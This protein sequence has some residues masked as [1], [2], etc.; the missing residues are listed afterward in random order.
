MEVEDTL[1]YLA[2]RWALR[3]SLVDHRTGVTGSFAGDGE[4][5]TLGPRGRYEERGRLRLGD[6]EGSVRR[7]LDLV[8]SDGAAI[9]VRFTDGRPFFELDLSRGVAEAVHHCGRDRYELRFEVN[10]GDLLLEWWR[11]TG[12]HKSYDARTTWQRV[13]GTSR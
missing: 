10:A 4:V 12:P 3:R 1:G 8:R 9:D 2:G 7:A 5:Q 13:T 11:V 6:H